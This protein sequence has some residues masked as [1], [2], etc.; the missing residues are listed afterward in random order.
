MAGIKSHGKGIQVAFYW[1]GRRYRPT[2]RIPATSAN[3][4]YAVRLKAEIERAIAL[5]TYTMEQYARHFPTSRASRLVA[6][7]AAVTPSETFEEYSKKWL[8]ASA[9]LSVGTLIKYRQALEF[10]NARIGN[11]PISEIPHSTIAALAN[12]QGWAAKNRNNMLIPMRRTFDMAYQDG[13]IERNPAERIR[14]AKVQKEPPDPLSAEEVEL[15]LQ[16]MSQYDRQI[17]NLFEFSFFSGMRPSELIALRWGDIDWN[18]ALARVSRAKTFGEEH[19]TKTYKVR[20]VE[21]NTRAL[22][23]LTRQKEHTFLKGSYVFENPVTGEPYTEERPLRRAYWNP[24]LKALGM[25]FRNFYQT[26][27][28]FATLNLMAGATPMWVAKQLGHSSMQMV[29]TVYS[30]WIDGADKSR[31]RSKID[32]LFEK[33]A[34]NTPQKVKVAQKPNEI[35]SGREDLNLRPLAPHASTLP[36]C[37]TPREHAL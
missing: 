37:A 27:H 36:G 6:D 16:R 29:L 9:H 13:V 34:T 35:W 14:N 26:R 28:T 18:R 33:T 25:R 32:E 22:S 19:E 23:A 24:T 12:S 5:G 7:K 3:L 2:L 4:K 31:E 1:N 8:A 17:V 21:L 30:R 15:V 10:W 11:V 20:D